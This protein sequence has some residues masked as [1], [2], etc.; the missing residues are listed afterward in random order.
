M[1]KIK[2]TRKNRKPTR[3][4]NKANT[5]ESQTNSKRRHTKQPQKENEQ[6][7]KKKTIDVTKTSLSFKTKN[8]HNKLPKTRNRALLLFYN[9]DKN[10][11]NTTQENF[12]MQMQ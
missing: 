6:S 12:K 7:I 8:P 2:A 4:K 5:E 11:K 10:Y 1:Y 9:P 3:C